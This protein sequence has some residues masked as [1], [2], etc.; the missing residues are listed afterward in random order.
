MYYRHNL[1]YQYPEKCDEHMIS[2]KHIR[3][4]NCDEHYPY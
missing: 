2:V 4:V 1:N 3:D